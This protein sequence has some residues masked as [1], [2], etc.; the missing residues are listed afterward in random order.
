MFQTYGGGHSLEAL[1]PVSND[2]A[3]TPISNPTGYTQMGGGPGGDFTTL[4]LCFDVLVN[5]EY[6]SGV[7][8]GNEVDRDEEVAAGLGITGAGNTADIVVVGGAGL[9]V[10][11]GVSSMM[12]RLRGRE[13]IIVD[14][15]LQKEEPT[16]RD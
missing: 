7:V 10:G 15:E 5:P 1:G 4:V 14:G 6:R 3:V 11:M 12:V 13:P 2:P 8:E 9:I 16:F